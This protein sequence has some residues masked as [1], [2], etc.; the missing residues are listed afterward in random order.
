MSISEAFLEQSAITWLSQIGYTHLDGAVIAPG[1]P[2]SER[3]SFDDIFLRGRL[4]AA[5]ARLN[6]QLPLS[7]HDQILRHITHHTAQTDNLMRINQHYHRLLRIG[8]PLELRRSDGSVAG[9]MATIVDFDHPERND[10]VVVSQLTVVNGR[11][12]RRPDLVLYVNGIPLI[13]IELKKPGDEYVSIDQAFQQLQTYKE[14]I[15]GLFYANLGL[16][17]S[18]GIQ[19]QVG[20]LSASRE[21]FK[22]WR[23]VDGQHEATRAQLELEVL[24]HGML[25]PT[26]LLALLRDFVAYESDAKGRLLKIL[27][28]YHQFHAVRHAVNETVRAS[29]IIRERPDPY[30]H[31]GVG[32]Q[33]GDRRIGVVWHTQGS[34]KSLSMLFYAGQVAR[35]PEMHNPTI[36]VLTDRNDLDDQLFG[37]FDRCH[38]V[39]GQRPRQAGSRAELRQLLQVASGGVIFS[40]IQKF[41]PDQRGDTM[42]ILSPRTNIVVIADEAHRS[43]YDLIDGLA[44]NLRDA[45]PNASFIGFTGTPI[46]RNDAH[47]RA[48]FGDY[49]SIYDIEQAVRD[50]ATVPI[51]YESRIARL[52][53]NDAELPRVDSEFEELT[54]GEE[55]DQRQRLKSKWAA[56]EALV[57]E[58]KRLAL[59]ANDIVAHYEQRQ[60]AITGKAM[61]VCMSR[62][63]AVALHEQIIALRPEWTGDAHDNASAESGT[64]LKVIM[65]GSASDPSHWQAHIRNAPARREL[66]WR[67]K[68]PNDPFKIVIVR[69]MWLTGFDAPVLHTMYIDK[70]M[71][72]HGLMQ[73]I[74]R[75]NRVFRDKPGGLVVDY[76][77]LAEQLKHAM[78]T[79]TSSG[80]RG[81]TT[82]QIEQ[83]FAVLQE[84]CEVAAALFHRFDWRPTWQLPDIRRLTIILP[85]VDVILGLADGRQRLITVVDDIS[86]AF[87]L[88]ATHP[89]AI[90][91]RDDIAFYQLVR[92]TLIKTTP[93][94]GGGID[95]D[96]AIQQLVSRSITTDGG[97]INVFEMAGLPNPDISLISEQFLREVRQI[98]QKNVA[99]ELLAKLLDG[100]I[101][102]I[103]THNVV[104]SKQLSAMLKAT[105]SQYQNRALTTLEV[106]EELIRLAEELQ[107]L[108]QRNEALGLNDDELAFYDA[109]AD[110]KSAIDLMGDSQLITIAKALV[111]QIRS[112]VSVDWHLR[113]SARA[114]MRVMVRRILRHHKY[115]PDLQ[116]Q[117]VD[118]VLEQTEVLCKAW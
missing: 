7:T 97:V 56:L 108:R 80:G 100:Q 13:V 53:L 11:Y 81:D 33:L 15:P 84:R 42:P 112:S 40:T 34:G 41:L 23:T 28:G 73:A 67:F 16:I 113:E 5:I 86:R 75:V 20:S 46:E 94:Q 52:A 72:G 48:V 30:Q 47:T 95:L 38:D 24:I 51:Y 8:V 79:Y 2:H 45:L 31:S 78:A 87:A 96:H 9:H 29:R 91:L 106:I 68:D 37:Q 77:G 63:I 39:I 54:E 36:V 65:T 83:A 85:A 114:R 10:W 88:C 64:V 109:L 19:A 66:A 110:N 18:D 58:P 69:D 89:Q 99:A 115:P 107:A 61:I 71:R 74:A 60:N 14:Q 111:S 25:T 12:Q 82:Q 3:E 35:H 4:R 27:A 70:P 50:G 43:Q 26:H 22:V 101:R 17:I 57:G 116:D 59:I 90:L 49:I 92:A 32:G 55:E 105:M 102:R 76:L 93:R 62:R 6:P 98:P 21:W 103:R 117:A 118:T 44:R 1:E 104:Q